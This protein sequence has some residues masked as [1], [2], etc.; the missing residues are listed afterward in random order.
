MNVYKKE[1]LDNAITFFVHEHYHKTN[2]SISQTKL[3]KYLAYFEIEVFKQTGI[4]PLELDFTAWERGP[5][6]VGLRDKIIHNE[7]QND[8]VSIKIEK[9]D[10]KTYVTFSPVKGKDYNLDYFSENEIDEM[11]RLVEIF[12]D[13][14]VKASDM[15]ESSHKDFAS[16]RKAWSKRGDKKCV[17]MHL[18]DE[19]PSNFRLKTEDKL[20][21]E[22]ENY[23]AYEALKRA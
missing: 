22:E 16:W 4:P 12:A 11:F 21:I 20:K 19:F 17:E 2:S 6:P 23:L 15:S 8:T 3:W 14:F 10:T 1:R 9:K 13:I 5:V 7:Y 18:T